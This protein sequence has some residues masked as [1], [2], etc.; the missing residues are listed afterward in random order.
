MALHLKEPKLIKAK[1]AYLE[2]ANWR[3]ANVILRD[4]DL[5]NLTMGDFKYLTWWYISDLDYRS[6]RMCEIMSK[7]ICHASRLKRDDFRL[8]GLPMSNRTCV[9]CDMFCIEDVLHI[10]NQCPFY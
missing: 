1:N 7:I 10:V 3:A 4:N 5:S 8:K 9:L 2:D 6:T